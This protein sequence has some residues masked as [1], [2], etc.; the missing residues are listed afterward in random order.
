MNLFY[1]PQGVGDV[2]FL[3]I[4]PTDGAYDYNKKDDVV[5]I[6]QD[7]QVVGYNIFN[8]SDKIKI[9]G[10][11][12]IKLTSEIIEALQQSINNSGFNYKLDTDLSPK[13]VVGYVETKE[14]HPDAD[15]LSVLKVN[16]GNETLQIVCGA[17]NVAAE[18][19]VVVAKVG[20]VMP[21]GMVIKDAKLRGVDSSGMIC[22]MKELDLPN[23]PQEKGIMV[24]NDDYEIGQAFFE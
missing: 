24:L 11:G 16:V 19:K 10:N 4:E 7:G 13:F 21:S 22:S 15:K 1:N 20:A 14:K 23:A 3:Q 18:Q 8:V 9:E 2:A 12:H 17:P 6:T 5:E